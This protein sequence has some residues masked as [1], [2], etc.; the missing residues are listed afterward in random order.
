MAPTN[1][2]VNYGFTTK[3]STMPNVAA[4]V[5]SEIQKDLSSKLSSKQDVTALD[6]S[7]V[8]AIVSQLQAAGWKVIVKQTIQP[9]TG[10]DINQVGQ[11]TVTYLLV[12]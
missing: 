5:A 1:K 3:T 4:L 8:D 10:V 12:S 11:K 2:P 9:T 7:L 6:K